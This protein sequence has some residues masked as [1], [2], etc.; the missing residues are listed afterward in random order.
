MNHDGVDTGGRRCVGFLG[1]L[2]QDVVVYRRTGVRTNTDTPC[3][4]LRRRGGSA[5]TAAAAAAGVL[6]PD[7]VRFFGQVGADD[8]GDAL[9]GELAA[10]GVQPCVRRGGRTGTVVVLVGAD[11]ERTMLTDRGAC[12]SLDGYET[13]WLAD[14]GILHVAGYSLLQD[15]LASVARRMIGEVRRSGGA[16]SV[17]ACSVGAIAD[18]GVAAFRATLSGIVPDVLLCDAGEASLLEATGG[19]RELAVLVVV[20]D[21]PRPT[22]L[23][24]EGF[25]GVALTPPR[26]EGVP[27]TTGA[28]DS[29]AGGLLAARLAG[30]AW[31]DAIVAGHTTAAVHL[32]SQAA[33]N[34]ESDL[35]IAAHLRALGTEA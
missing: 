34:A 9:L 35:D 4:I 2:L 1:D 8:V 18:A 20:K 5:A 7:R 31:P 30:N 25:D 27:D 16:V 10:C 6:G 12:A 14:L 23:F 19:Y 21:G 11:G 17:D 13:T 26:L 24:G 32:L 3:D 33:T 28:G 15:P 22:R 29:F